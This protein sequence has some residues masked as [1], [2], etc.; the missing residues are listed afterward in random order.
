MSDGEDVPYLLSDDDRK[1]IDEAYEESTKEV[2]PVIC[3]VRIHRM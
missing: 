3:D 2:V 1:V